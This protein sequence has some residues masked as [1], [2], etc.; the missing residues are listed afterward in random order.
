MMTIENMKEFVYL[1]K[2]KNY[3]IAAE[4]LYMTQATLSRHIIAMEKELG[5]SLIDR[6]RR[7]IELTPN[8]IRFLSY[9]ER[10]AN[11]HESFNQELNCRLRE[12]SGSLTLGLAYSMICYDLSGYIG[13][14]AD[15]YPNI[16]LSVLEAQSD[17]LVEL[18]QTGTCDFVFRREQVRSHQNLGCLCLGSDTLVMAVN[19]NH[20]MANSGG[21][22]LED[23]RDDTFILSPEQSALETVKSPNFTPK[24]ASIKG[25]KGRSLFY[26]IEHDGYVS[27]FWKRLGQASSNE[28]VKLVDIVPQRS[29]YINLLY[30][31]G[32][33]SPGKSRF[34]KFMTACMEGR[35]SLF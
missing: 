11:L 26:F 9:A 33:M 32:P 13:K 5:F 3:Q 30:R 35:G 28:H 31:S 2:L 15:T 22:A 20:P 1:A 19:E 25:T 18:L 4:R 21:A 8:G 34:L 23:F 10:I 7:Q 24:L 14:F 6:S 12:T 29:A 16:H 17:S 27:P